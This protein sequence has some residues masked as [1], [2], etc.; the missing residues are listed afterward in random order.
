ML[1]KIGIVVAVIA[2]GVASVQTT[3]FARGGGGGGGGGHFGGGGFGGG[4][5]HIGG[6][7]GGG[8]FGGGGGFAGRGFGGGFTSRNVGGHFAGPGLARGHRFV[9]PFGFGGGDWGWYC[10]QWP[11]GYYSYYGDGCY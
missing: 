8:H 4:G 6:F 9:R 5:G 11:Y 7:G 2:L 1:R 10:N 3:A